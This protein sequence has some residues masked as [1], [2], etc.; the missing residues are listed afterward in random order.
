MEYGD[1]IYHY[2]ARE[3]L[4]SA[5][6]KRP[7]FLMAGQGPLWRAP[8]VARGGHEQGWAEATMASDQAA[9]EEAVPRW[10]NVWSMAQSMKAKVEPSRRDY[11][12]AAI[13]TMIEI[14]RQSNRMLLQVIQA[15]RAINCGDKAL[16]KTHLLKANE[17]L[18]TI[19]AAEARAEYGKWRHWYCGD[20]LTGIDR[21]AELVDIATRL[22]DDPRAPIPVGVMWNEREAYEH[23]TGYQGERTVDL[24]GSHAHSPQK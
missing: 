22:Q 19:K 21:T 14:N 12:E 2:H 24:S 17:S 8:H 6:V 10:E 16:A 11:Y 4:L 15:V 5:L 7:L 23:I 13:L 18:N 9:C 20:W 3:L 1:M